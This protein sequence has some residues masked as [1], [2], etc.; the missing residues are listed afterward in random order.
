[1]GN[2]AS[3]RWLVRGLDRASMKCTIYDYRPGVCRDYQAG[4]SECIGE[5][6]RHLGQHLKPG[7][8]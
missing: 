6:T 5:R 7:N 2:A 1:M 3:R 8:A 4:A